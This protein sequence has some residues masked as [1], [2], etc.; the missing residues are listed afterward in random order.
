L[1]DR[2]DAV[3]LQAVAGLGATADETC[4]LAGR[5]DL[6]A[7]ALARRRLHGDGRSRYES[8]DAEDGAPVPIAAHG[9]TSM[10]ALHGD[11]DT[12]AK[13]DARSLRN[14]VTLVTNRPIAAA[15]MI[16]G[17]RGTVPT[18]R[19]LAQIKEMKR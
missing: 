10:F 2:H 5:P 15:A 17:G 9:R 8:D 3:D 11:C 7:W 19:S 6:G 4:L 1:H 13:R 14:A 16:S 18:S 12:M